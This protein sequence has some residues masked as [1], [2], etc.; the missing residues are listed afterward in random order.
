MT[1]SAPLLPLNET[2]GGPDEKF[3]SS[4]LVDFLSSDLPAQ[5]LPIVL[6]ENTISELLSEDLVGIYWDMSTMT[7]IL[8]LKPNLSEADML[9]YDRKRAS[10]QHRLASLQIPP[11]R[12]RHT[13]SLAQEE[14]KVYAQESCRIAGVIYSNMTLW[15]FQHRCTSLVT[16]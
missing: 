12:A 10:I 16:W 1:S 2:Y 3:S 11:V 5:S 6:Q 13:E 8:D 7:A 9:V 15:G 14:V 4:L